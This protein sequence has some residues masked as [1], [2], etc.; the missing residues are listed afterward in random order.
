MRWWFRQQLHIQIFICI[1][2]GIGLG[3][4][5]GPHATVLKPIGDIFIRLLKMLIVPLTFFTLISGITKMEDLRSLRSVGG[6][7][8]L[9]YS[10]TSLLAAAMGMIVALII[11][12]GKEALGLLNVGVHIETTQFNFIENIVNW[13]PTNPIQAMANTNMLQVIVFSL[14]VG[15]SLLTLGK[16]VKGL[17]KLVDEGADLMI[18][19]TEFVMKTAPYGILALIANMVGTLGTKMLSEVGRFIL[20][21]SV[22]IILILICAYPLLLK[23]FGNKYPYRFYRNV[24][25]A[26][27]VAASTTS[28]AATLPVAMRV[29]SKNLGASEK[30]YGFTLPL[31]ATINMDGMAA[32]IG[33]IAVF[34]ANLYGVPIT[35]ALMFQFV[36]LGLVLSIGTAGIKGAGVVMSTILLQTLNMPLTLVPILAAVWP[37]IDIAH[38]T[39]N[40]TGDLNGTTIIGSR[41]NELNEEIYMGAQSDESRLKPK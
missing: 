28:S 15:I 23:I 22:A 6:M 31:G 2:I 10:T 14:I 18:K 37:I 30:I 4:L 40:V 13:I 36:F 5:L 21:D 3:F 11:R 25:P 39:C 19:I 12:P 20:A 8:L 1:T 16:R 17:L 7:T 33:V 27:L 38:T 32:A 26:M 34:A 35:A 24:A 41:L 29:A 9:Y